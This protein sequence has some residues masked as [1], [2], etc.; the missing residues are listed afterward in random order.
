MARGSG[1]PYN[2]AITM[3]TLTRRSLSLLF[4]CCLVISLSPAS[5]AA[6]GS[7]RVLMLY[8]YGRNFAAYGAISSAFETELAEH[9]RTPIQFHEVSLPGPL[10]EPSEVDEPTLNFLRGLFGGDEPDLIVPFGGPAVRFAL[11][12]REQVFPSAP[13][14]LAG[15]EARH[16]KTFTLDTNTTAVA[17]TVDFPGLIEHARR[18]LPGTTN[19]AV[20]PGKSRLEVFWKQQLQREFTV[21]INQL[22]F[23]WLDQ[24][25]LA[26]MQEQVRRL[27]PHTAIFYVT[28]LLDA[29]G[30][31][32]DSDKAIKA[33]H[34]AANAPMIGLSEQGFGLGSVGGPMRDSRVPG[35][36]TARVA[37][38][39]LNGE[40]PGDIHVPPMTPLYDWRELRRWNIREDRLPPGSV[41]KFREPPIWERHRTL[42]IG[43]PSLL[44]VQSALIASL[45]LN[46]GRRRK[47]ERLLRESEERMKLAADA[48]E[49]GMWEWDLAND[50]VWL[51]GRGFERISRDH[52]HYNRFLNEVHPEDRDGVAQA[53]AKA[54]VGDGT[55]EHVY[56]HLLPDGQVRWIAARA[57]VEFDA[58]HKPKK[59]R[60]AAL[61]ITAR[62]VAEDRARES[63][64]EFLLIANSA[65]VM[66]W[67]S[68]P[69]KLCTFVN[70][71]W[72]EF[73][74]RTLE[75]E[76]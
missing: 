37:T 22:G 27:P 36:G 67:T 32:Y 11:R 46:L 21:F 71:R 31:P 35:Q 65:A 34:A 60:G 63:E 29:A 72:L 51:E 50:K 58:E 26:E 7:K 43:G 66:I 8:S 1:A 47:A 4:L 20:V 2:R 40:P 24:Y 54:I 44:V 45:V 75:Q 69:D 14:L 74:G 30:V 42:L 57:R 55:F 9:S 16:L 6:V 13:L 25:N 23:I 38:R 10:F 5:A 3:G 19:F 76:L 41:V 68:G 64:K 52:S 15:V 62:K 33:L 56:R 73:R 18:I 70:Q 39:I 53:V 28:L 17:I 49:L 59:M 48:A 12:S 61:D